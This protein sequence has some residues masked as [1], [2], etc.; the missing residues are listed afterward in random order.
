MRSGGGYPFVAMQYV[1]HFGGLAHWS[2]WPYKN[3]C[4]DDACGGD[5]YDG[6]PTCRRGK[7]N[8][9]IKDGN[10]TAI[11]GWQMVAMGAE[12]EELMRVAL[13]KVRACAA[14]LSQI[15]ADSSFPAT[16]RTDCARVQ[17]QRDGLLHPRGD[18]LHPRLVRLRFDRS[19]RAL[20]SCRP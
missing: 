8:R 20:R 3:L 11:S 1:E 9:V 10:G 14:F 17:R 2:D 13:T 5:A 6:T 18:R 19:P 7:V 4:M 16:E 15:R 12:Y